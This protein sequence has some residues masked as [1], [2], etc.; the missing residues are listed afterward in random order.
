MPSEEKKVGASWLGCYARAC[1]FV[2]VINS[3]VERSFLAFFNVYVFCH[4]DWC[5][6]RDSG[7]WWHHKS[8]WI[9]L[10]LRLYDVVFNGIQYCV[11]NEH[12]RVS[13]KNYSIFKIIKINFVITLEIEKHAQSMS[14]MILISK[15]NQCVQTKWAIL[16]FSQSFTAND[17]IFQA[18]NKSSFCCLALVRFV[19]LCTQCHR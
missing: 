4:L 1:S 6:Y 5:T 8:D 17:I 14:E 18:S 2:G 12:V 19:L 15:K 11:F 10:K 3:H 9:K 13:K 7:A 16:S